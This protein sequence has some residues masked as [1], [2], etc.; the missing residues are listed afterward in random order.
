MSG[1]CPFRDSSWCSSSA[2]W[3]ESRRIGADKTEE[4]VPEA[5]KPL[6]ARGYEW[7][8]SAAECSQFFSLS[9]S[10]QLRGEGSSLLRMA[11]RCHFVERGSL[12]G[13]SRQSAWSHGDQASR[14]HSIS[15][16][17]GFL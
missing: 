17:K 13:F 10:R 9:F 12:S 6:V 1:D 3:A 2:G 11:Y 4:A 7:Q 5:S 8:I 14:L 16:K 15:L